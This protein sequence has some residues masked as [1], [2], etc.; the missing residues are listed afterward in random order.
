MPRIISVDL[1]AHHV[2]VATWRGSR[3]V[4]ALEDHL[5][6]RVPQG[7]EH[8]PNLEARLA[9]LDAMLE[10]SPQL[11]GSGG[12][13]VVLA[14]PSEHASVHRVTLPFKDA[15]Q[16]AQTLPFT[17]EGEVPFE[18]EDMVMGWRSSERENGTEVMAVLVEKEKLS[19]WIHSLA[20]RG[21]DPALVC[22]DAEV[23]GRIPTVNPST[24]ALETEEVEEV[25]EVEEG[26]EVEEE[27]EAPLVTLTAVLDLGHGC[28]RLSV[29]REGTVVFFRSMAIGGRTMTRAIQEALGCTWE[30]AERHKHGDGQQSSGYGSL[31]PAARQA[32]D[33]AV[34][35]LLAD[36]RASLLRVEDEQA[37]EVERIWLM[38][39][40]THI[41]E[42]RD[43]FVRD[44]GVEVECVEAVSS[45][46]APE[47]MMAQRLGD[48]MMNQHEEE[49]VDLRVGD[50]SY[51]GGTD[52]VRAMLTY[53]VAG[54]AFFLV[55]IAVMS[56]V[57]WTS[58]DA[59]QEGLEER[60]RTQVASV[61]TD[62]APGSLVDADMAREIMALET[63]EAV[64]RA[65]GL[66]QQLGGVPPTVDLLYEV[67]EAFPP[68]DQVT[69]S[70][71]EF[72]VTATMVTFSAETDGYASSSAVEEALR[73]VPRFSSASKGTETRMA[74][75]R[76]KFPI[77][78]ALGVEDG[79]VESP[80][81][82]SNEEG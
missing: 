56:F 60:V 3:G 40:G 29:V 16:V 62:I 7:E 46:L 2:R 49:V 70:V 31:P 52:L 71:S 54:V 81:S 48:V 8:P 1:G 38:G 50:L 32:V 19:N 57:Q 10:E 11:A 45:E 17:V 80:D 64:Q 23:I 72:T 35:R 44:L 58:M 77:T 4:Y 43:Y 63:A 42:L 65:Q 27:T 12:D 18:M 74:N 78:I 53:G 14:F 55:T 39:G 6:R 66:T 82:E 9:A 15:A 34:G 68:S 51:R 75:G 5:S 13:R 21:F 59:E 79:E 33:G 69:V 30:E 22:C 61:L 76:V 26:E 24:D 47:F 20:E 73:S 25:E 36:V 67:H 37:A 41:E 28:S